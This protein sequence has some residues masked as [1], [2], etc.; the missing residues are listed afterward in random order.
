MKSNFFTLCFHSAALPLSFVDLIW[1]Q[2]FVVGRVK[3]STSNLPN[4]RDFCFW[5][6]GK[7]NCLWSCYD[8][9]YF[10]LSVQGDL[11]DSIS[12]LCGSDGSVKSGM[13]SVWLEDLDHFA[14]KDEVKCFPKMDKG[15]FYR[16]G[17]FHL[18]YDSPECCPSLRFW[19]Y[20]RW[21]HPWLLS[22]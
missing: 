5:C 10:A 16:D 21:E 14:P 4:L 7:L 13:Y 2:N 9:E 11:F 3:I 15:Q 17:C 8:I 12:I 19:W 1:K 6:D 18:L 20:L 22:C